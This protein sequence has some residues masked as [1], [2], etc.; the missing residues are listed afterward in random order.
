M[1]QLDV[2]KNPGRFI[3]FE[4]IDGAGTTT[5]QVLLAERLRLS[6]HDVIETREPTSGPIGSLIR[7]AIM[8]EISIGPAEMAKL[9]AADR[10]HHIHNQENGIAAS[11]ADGKWVICDRYIYS[12]LAYQ[13][14]AGITFDEVVSL[15]S[16]ILVPDITILIM[17]SIDECM[18]RIHLR[19]TNDELYHEKNLLT[20][21]ISLYGQAVSRH[22]QYS[23]NLIVVDG[24]TDIEG[25]SSQVWAGLADLPELESRAY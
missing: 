21:V 23:G 15:N 6:G 19:S 12:N 2:R 4:G 24:N 22:P 1:I 8:K 16:N 14:M 20:E 10:G 11:L 9:F 3:V 18:R 13:A 17:T 25:V 5:Q 7:R